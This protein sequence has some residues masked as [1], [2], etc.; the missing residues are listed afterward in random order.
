MRTTVR[1]D[2]DLLRELKDRARQEKTTLTRIVNLLLRRGISASGDA[3][4][5]KRP[6]RE[7]TFAMGRPQVDMTK[8]LA[9]AAQ[10]DDE[11]TI[12]QLKL[13]R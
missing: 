3:N 8:A 4:R 13:G 12:K 7:K 2:D 1:I 11:E 6:Y 5:R 10:L 9:L